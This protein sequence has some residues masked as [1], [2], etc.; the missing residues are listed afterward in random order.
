MNAEE[1]TMISLV[2]STIP[3]ACLILYLSGNFHGTKRSL[4]MA[5]RRR[6][7][8]NKM[9]KTEFVEDIIKKESWNDVP[10]MNCVVAVGE[11]LFVN[12]LHQ[13]FLSLEAGEDVADVVVVSPKHW[14]DM[15]SWGYGSS[16]VT[17]DG[18]FYKEMELLRANEDD[19]GSSI[20]GANIH[21]RDD[22]QENMVL[23]GSKSRTGFARVEIYKG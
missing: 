13:A 9:N 17:Q 23:V 21:V 1:I 7:R 19:N 14:K 5:N 22:I 16:T 2:F 10:A 12:A 18:E 20:W 4:R 6:E 8:N 3:I 15:E 11:V